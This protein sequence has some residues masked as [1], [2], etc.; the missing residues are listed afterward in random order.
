MVPGPR[1]LLTLTC[2]Y[3]LALALPEAVVLRNARTVPYP[4]SAIAMPSPSTSRIQLP[5]S[6]FPH[7]TS[8]LARLA[9]RTGP[10]EPELEL[11]RPA[12]PLAPGTVHLTV[13]H[14]GSRARR[15]RHLYV[16]DPGSG[17][18]GA[19][20]CQWYCRRRFRDG[21]G[22]CTLHRSRFASKQTRREGAPRRT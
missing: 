15:R 7:S 6:N 13:G 16:L 20:E 3:L 21:M 8:R 22:W 18:G 5:A 11:P 2:T 1:T 4:I 10:R 19:S 9:R 17:G 14:S 12:T